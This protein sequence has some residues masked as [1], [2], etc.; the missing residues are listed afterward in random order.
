MN[1]SEKMLCQANR[2]DNGQLVIG[3]YFCMHHND[4]RK[5]IHHFIIPLEADLSIGTP[6]E[7]IQVEIDPDTVHLTLLKEQEAVDK[8]I[9]RLAIVLEEQP[10][11][12]R[13]KDCKY[14]DHCN[15]CMSWHDVNSN[16]D[17]W[18]CADGERRD[19]D[20]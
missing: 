20:D 19:T 1:V 17:N 16:N 13:C 8:T 2:K 15:G 9:E 10:E 11:I 18:Y 12:V 3:Y 5:H 7:K 14:Y 4:E 6:I